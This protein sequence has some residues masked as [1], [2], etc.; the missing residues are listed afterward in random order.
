MVIKMFFNRKNKQSLCPGDLVVI[1]DDGDSIKPLTLSN[2]LNVGKI[3]R[4]SGR[5]IYDVEIFDGPLK[6]EVFQIHE[7]R[8]TRTNGNILIRWPSNL[9]QIS[10]DDIEL[11][12]KI[13]SS[14]YMDEDLESNLEGLIIK[15]K[16]Y[17]SIRDIDAKSLNRT[18]KR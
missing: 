18:I 11:L 15:L 4:K 10:D 16:F 17:R 14:C 13:K 5:E 2:E 8:L 9:V 7:S 6:S 3:I 1:S 12:S